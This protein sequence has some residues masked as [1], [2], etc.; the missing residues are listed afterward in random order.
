MKI[1]LVEDSAVDRMFVTHSLR[2]VVDFECDLVPCDSLSK[3]FE[4]LA[5]ASFD[6]I[7]L[8]LWLPDSEGMQTCQ[9]VVSAVRGTPV[10]VMTGTDD[11]ALATEAIRSGAQ[12]YLVKGAFPGS[13]MARVLQYAIDR[14]HFHQ[15]FAQQENQ[16]RQILSHVPAIIWTT[17][18]DL[19]VTSVQGAG[20]QQIA[21]DPDQ[22]LGK[23]LDATLFAKSDCDDAASSSFVHSHQCAIAGHAESLESRYN[24]RLFEV[25][26][27]PLHQP[28]TGIVGAIGIALDVTE[29]RNLD[30]EINFARLIQQGLLPAFHPQL[31]G[32]DIFG[33]SFPA[34]QT[35]GDW[36][37]YLMFPDGSLGL[38]VGDVSGKGFG[39]AILSAT[40]AAYLDVLAESHTDIH[41]I[42][43]LCNRLICKRRLDGQFAVLSL[44]QLHP[45]QR[46]ITYGGAGEEIMIIDRD[47]NQKQK[48]LSSG[49]PLGLFQDSRYDDSATVSLE[50]DDI[51]LFLT[52]GFR[53][54]MNEYD[55]QFGD[56]RIVESVASNRTASAR[57]I[58]LALRQSACDFAD[59]HSQQDDMTGIVV[60]VLDAQD[61]S[62]QSISG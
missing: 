46:T 12:D 54:A 50:P 9:R 38:V 59:I 53:E 49:Y 27:D 13:A 3:A 56:T 41:E 6:V 35:C 37:D 8:D 7:L 29:R 42:L 55:E 15:D 52:D 58:F 62:C 47:G 2:E 20:L 45:G 48:V 22:V 25:K 24:D 4:H 43:T 1:L 36:F 61:K 17:D 11:R 21:L 18:C 26:I 23:S 40:M 44:G 16:F 31:D 10:I 14:F 5:K 19:L 51:L 57:E 33:G 34:K 39:P 60:K 30:H 32:F 28:E